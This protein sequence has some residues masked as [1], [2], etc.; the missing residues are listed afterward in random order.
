MKHSMEGLHYKS[1][2]TIRVDIEQ[3]IISNIAEIKSS[4][5]NYWIAPGLVD[6]QVNG[7]RGKDFNQEDTNIEDVELITKYLWETGVTTYFPT[8]ITNSDAN[9]RHS[10]QN[11]VHACKEKSIKETIGGIHL[12]GPFLSKE[13][14]PRGAHPLEFIQAPNWDLFCKWQEIAEGKIKMITLSPEWLASTAFI[15]KCVDRGVVVAIGHTA[16]SPAQIQEAVAAGAS[17]STHLGNAT[18][19]MLP[20]HSNYIWE[21]LASEGLWSTIIADGFHLPDS[22]LKVLLKVKPEMTVLVSD[23]TKFAG[24]KPGRYHSH[25]GGDIELDQQGRLFMK[26]SPDFLAGSAKSLLDCIE[27]LSNR[28]ITSLA[29]AVDMASIKALEAIKARPSFGLEIGKKA[30]LMVFEQVE[31]KINIVQTIKAGKIVY[32][33]T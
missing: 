22:L 2:K 1:L 23:A 4:K 6:L 15:S 10:I 11:I 21:Q 12:E 33:R 30:D 3:D 14:G 17:I 18:H 5:N 16:A 24:M 32:S 28:Q 20:R 29:K 9:I 19:A 27:N 8:L 7:F 31:G 25:I 13:N 26:D